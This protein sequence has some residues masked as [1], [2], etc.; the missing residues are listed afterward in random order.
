MTERTET[1]DEAAEKAGEGGYLVR[2]DR[3]RCIAS[4]SCVLTEPAVFDQDL[5]DGFVLLRDPR[6]GRERRRAVLRAV[7]GCPAGA[8]SVV[9]PA[10]E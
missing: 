1:A 10:G 7:D 9:E 5:T 2:A 6:P 8:L 3:S 4:G